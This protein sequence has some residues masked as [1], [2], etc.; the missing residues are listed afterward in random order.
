MPVR[1][2]WRPDEIILIKPDGETTIEP[3]E[4]HEASVTATTAR[5]RAAAAKDETENPV[6]RDAMARAARA[7]EAKNV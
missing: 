5:K 4:K 3:R 2:M 6:I 7:R 1:N